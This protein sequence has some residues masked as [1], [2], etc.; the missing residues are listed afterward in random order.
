MERKNIELKDAPEH[1]FDQEKWAQFVGFFQGDRAAAVAFISRAAPRILHV[2]KQHHLASSGRSEE[3]ALLDKQ[4]GLADELIQNF[5]SGFSD[6][7]STASGIWT[8]TCARAPITSE[9]WKHFKLQPN[10]LSQTV[11]RKVRGKVEVFAEAVLISETSTSASERRVELCLTLLRPLVTKKDKARKNAKPRAQS[12]IPDLTDQEFADAYE[13]AYQ[14]K[15]GRPRNEPS[16][17]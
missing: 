5:V 17:K 1:F 7:R 11:E 13:A 6:G 12:A 15:R 3:K 10:F 2:L 8:S 9:Q 14:R 4:A 16:E